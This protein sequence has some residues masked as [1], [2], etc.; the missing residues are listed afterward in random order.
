MHVEF[1][2]RLG[3]VVAR[4]ADGPFELDAADA[5][6]QFDVNGDGS[7]NGCAGDG[8]AQVDVEKDVCR[9]FDC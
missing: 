3:R 9:V 4:H 8:G 1:D 7:A 6:R 2:D 5:I